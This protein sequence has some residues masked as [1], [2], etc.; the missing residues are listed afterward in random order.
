MRRTG[1]VPFIGDWRGNLL[2]EVRG[3]ILEVGAGDGP[4]LKHYPREARVVATEFD[5]EAIAQ[6]QHGAA[7]RGEVD[8]ECPPPIGFR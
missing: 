8:G 2:R 3:H 6:A 4:N 5:Y 7:Q 1:R